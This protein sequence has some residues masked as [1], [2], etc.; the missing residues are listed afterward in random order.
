MAVTAVNDGPPVLTTPTAINY[1][2]TAFDDTFA[3]VTGS[4]VASDIDSTPITYGITGGT[5]NGDGTI[6]Q[7][8][9]YGV[10]TVNKA[11]G[12]YSFVAND[13]AIEALT[14]A[15]SI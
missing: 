5:D 8:S 1:I 7:S 9:A 13:A 2:D 6:S 10:L 4:L 11:T 3:T 15:A 12:A 14:I